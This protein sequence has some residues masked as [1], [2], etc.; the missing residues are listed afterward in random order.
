[1]SRA[2][3]GVVRGNVIVPDEPFA[4]PEGAEVMI[5]FPSNLSL[6]KHAGVWRDLDDLDKLVAEI[7]ESR[8]VKGEP[9][10]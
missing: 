6:L 9:A 5:D 8:T 1:M 2:I 4:L 10:S 3:K 7:Y